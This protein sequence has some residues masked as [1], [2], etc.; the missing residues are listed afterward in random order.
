MNG[1]EE[2]Q[3]IIELRVKIPEIVL[4]H[5]FPDEEDI[6][7]NPNFSLRSVSRRNAVYKGVINLLAIRGAKDFHTG[8]AIEFFT[9][10]DHHIFPRSR[11]VK[12]KT[13]DA[14]EHHEYKSEEI[15]TILNRTLISEGTH[16]LIRDH[17]P[18]EY[19]PEIVPSAHKIEIMASH[20]ID[21]HALAALES[22]RYDA[23]RQHRERCILTTLRKYLQA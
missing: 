15:N 8:D 13:N 10:E 7:A 19:I 2:M 6:L 4:T 5:W 22:D 21:E 12:K 20:F 23:F 3:R 1:G 9:L 18:S 16:K 11:L 14:G 17:W